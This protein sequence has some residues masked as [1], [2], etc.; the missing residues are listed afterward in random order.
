MDAS[1][2]VGVITTVVSFY[3]V[4]SLSLVFLNKYIFRYGTHPRTALCQLHLT[5]LSTYGQCNWA[6]DAT[7]PPSTSFR[8]HSL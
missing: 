4:V 1:Y 5:Y 2:S 8:T 3:W 6:F 7:A